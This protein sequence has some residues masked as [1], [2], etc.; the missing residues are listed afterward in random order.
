MKKAFTVIIE[1][2]PVFCRKL[3]QRFPQLRIFNIDATRLEPVLRRHHIDHIDTIVSSLPLLS[4][5][6][7]SQNEI[8]KQSFSLLG[9]DGSFIQ[10]TYGVGSP[11]RRHFYQHFELSGR[12][13]S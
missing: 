10:Y 5:D 11:I 6:K 8:L 2:D 12:R 13:I 9:Q 3:R 4:L 1:R 7:K